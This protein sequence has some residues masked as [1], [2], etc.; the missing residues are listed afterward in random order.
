MIGII[1]TYITRDCSAL[2]LKLQTISLLR[3]RNSNSCRNS[4]YFSAIEISPSCLT[5]SLFSFLPSNCVTAFVVL[6]SNTDF[7]RD[8]T[9]TCRNQH[10]HCPHSTIDISTSTPLFLIFKVIVYRSNEEKLIDAITFTACIVSWLLP[11]QT[12]TIPP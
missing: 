12:T 3:V 4:A 9:L 7:D 10:Q 5:A 8:K 2:L 1:C 6:P 11:W